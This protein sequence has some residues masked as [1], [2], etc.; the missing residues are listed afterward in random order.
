MWSSRNGFVACW[1]MMI[2]ITW[3]LEAMVKNWV[4]F[5]WKGQE[6]GSLCSNL[7]TRKR[8][9]MEHL[10]IRHWSFPGVFVS[11][12]FPG[13][14]KKVALL[15]QSKS[16][17]FEILF[18]HAP[19]IQLSE[20]MRYFFD[21]CINRTIE[22]IRSQMAQVEGKRNRVKVRS[23]KADNL[24]VQD[25]DLCRQFI[26]LAASASPNSCT[27]NWHFLWNCRMSSFADQKP[28]EFNLG[29]GG[30]F[31]THTSTL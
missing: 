30:W 25:N 7:K 28:R 17:Y 1:E 22:L 8:D 27:R 13:R 23:K 16:L 2:T 19:L 31:N 15:L 14:W 3:T 26:S 4:V 11:G 18:Y 9:F 10:Q 12:T 5:Q 6:W 24:V 29:P 20:D 21:Y